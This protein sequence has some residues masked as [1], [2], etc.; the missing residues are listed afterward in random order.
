[1]RA[2]ETKLAIWCATSRLPAT[3]PQRSLSYNYSSFAALKPTVAYCS[4]WKATGAYG[5]L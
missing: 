2:N 3:S 1:V 5:S 4:F